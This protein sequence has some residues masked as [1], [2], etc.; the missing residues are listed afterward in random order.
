VTAATWTEYQ[1]QAEQWQGE[2]AVNYTH[3]ADAGLYADRP[4][5]RFLGNTSGKLVLDVGCGNGYLLR[6]LEAVGI[7][8][9]GVEIAFEMLKQAQVTAGK[10]EEMLCLA[11]AEFLPFRSSTFDAAICSL[12]INNFARADIVRGLFQKV[13]ELLRT[14]GRFVISVP[15]PHTLDATTQFRW[16]DW[17]PGQSQH[18][19]VPGESFRRSI[20]G[21]DGTM[22]KIVNYYWP[23]DIIRLFAERAGF[24]AAGMAE[25]VASTDEVTRYRFEPILAEV[26]FFLVMNFQKQGPS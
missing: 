15:H 24:I 25:E 3:P 21:S 23:R 26:P 16:T 1:E 7:R 5:M 18:N 22:I 6:R 11:S 8:V 2:N 17:E 4:L 9:V 20:V 12:T 19:L 14:G 13:A 10:R